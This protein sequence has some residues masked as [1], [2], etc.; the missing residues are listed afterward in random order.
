MALDGSAIAL[1]GGAVVGSGNSA[2]LAQVSNGGH[3]Y[4]ASGI[5][6]TTSKALPYTVNGVDYGAPTVDNNAGCGI[7]V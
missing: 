7:Y 4:S 1:S 5:T 2:G 6:A 3:I